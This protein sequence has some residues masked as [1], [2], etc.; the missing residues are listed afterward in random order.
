MTLTGKHLG[1]MTVKLL[2]K[3][4]MLFSARFKGLSL[5]FPVFEMQIAEWRS[6]RAGERKA[7]VLFN[8]C[9]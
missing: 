1:D 6:S 8:E 7:C 4:N 5:V 2:Y 9:G 3:Y